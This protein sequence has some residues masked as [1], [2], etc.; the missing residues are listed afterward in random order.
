[1]RPSMSPHRNLPWSLKAL[2]S[3]AV[4]VLIGATFVSWSGVS[5]GA[6][7]QQELVPG[8]TYESLDVPT[9]RGTARA[10][11][12]AADL[13]NPKMSVNLLYPGDVAARQPLSAM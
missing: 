2:T 10:H 4:S 9:P 1:M 3:F 8:V 12:V 5:V 11:I 7:G 13:S 6:D